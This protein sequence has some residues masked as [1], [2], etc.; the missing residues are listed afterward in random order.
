LGRGLGACM[1]DAMVGLSLDEC[2]P[3]RNAVVIKAR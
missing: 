2:W 3:Y 1:V